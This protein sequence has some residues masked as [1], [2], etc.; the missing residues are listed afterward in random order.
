MLLCVRYWHWAT[1]SYSDLYQIY[2]ATIS[3]FIC[4]LFV[5]HPSLKQNIIYLY[6][7][8]WVLFCRCNWRNRSTSLHSSQKGILHLKENKGI[9]LTP[10]HYTFKLKK[11]KD[12]VSIK[13]TQTQPLTAHL[14]LSERTLPHRQTKPSFQKNT[15]CGSTMLWLFAIAVPKS[16]AR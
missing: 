10:H 4:K 12:T 14:L 7:S 9:K 13:N 1:E 6:S 11:V 8:I 3:H 15:Y 16:F 2:Q 5:S